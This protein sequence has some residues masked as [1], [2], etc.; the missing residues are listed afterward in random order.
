MC[1]TDTRAQEGC[2]SKVFEVKASRREKEKRR[3]MAEGKL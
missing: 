3:A 2:R 1:A